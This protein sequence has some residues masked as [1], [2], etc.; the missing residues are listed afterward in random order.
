MWAMYKIEW[1]LGLEII[2]KRMLKKYWNAKKVL[3]NKKTIGGR[4]R[5]TDAAINKLQLYYGLA[6]RRNAHKGV[7]AMKDAIWA[8]LFHMG[9][10]DEATCHALCPANIDPWCKYKLSQIN[11]TP[12]KHAEHTHLPLVIMEEIRPICEALFNDFLLSKCVHGGT[13]NV[14]ESLNSVIWSRIPKKVFVRIST[15]K[16]RVL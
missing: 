5:L 11:K 14:S 3:E 6:I 16:L 13:Q 12:Y 7:V 10:T 9:S 2:N 1:A 8:E 4:G 15:L